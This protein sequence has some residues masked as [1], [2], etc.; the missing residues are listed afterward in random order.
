MGVRH[1]IVYAGETEQD[2]KECGPETRRRCERAIEL[3]HQIKNK[4]DSVYMIFAAGIRPD[5]PHY[6]QLKEM[7]Q[8]YVR[9]NL[10]A[11]FPIDTVTTETDAWGTFTE[12]KSAEIEIKNQQISEVYVVSSWYHIP[13]IILIWKLIGN[14]KI[15]PIA[16]KSPKVQSFFL[17]LLKMIK[18]CIDYYRH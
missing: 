15:H 11:S 6:P 17:E 5:K 3:A 8:R 16:A 7:M 1:V 14:Y 10:P 12:S 4:G 9:T 13:R 18:V 2:G